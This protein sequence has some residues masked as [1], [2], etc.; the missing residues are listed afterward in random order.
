L[1]RILLFPASATPT[2]LIA[3]PSS[4]IQYTAG[5]IKI[6]QRG[7]S[8]APKVGR[9]SA[10]AS[11]SF[12]TAF[13]INTQGSKAGQITIVGCG[14]E[15][16]S[17]RYSQANPTIQ[18]PSEIAD[19]TFIGNVFRLDVAGQLSFAGSIDSIPS[20]YTLLAVPNIA[21]NKNGSAVV[22]FDPLAS[23]YSV[24]G[25]FY[26][27]STLNASKAQVTGAHYLREMTINGREASM[28]VVNGVTQWILQ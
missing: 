28:Y 27:G 25:K 6:S 19:C 18:I 11:D 12:M 8:T 5:Y 13:Q 1:G 16:L 23:A 2:T 20:S 10:N 3:V 14:M 26:G 9:G 7:F 22:S 15:N 17:V 21:I 24:D 4:N